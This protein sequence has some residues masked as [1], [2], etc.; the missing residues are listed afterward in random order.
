MSRWQYHFL[1]FFF[2]QRASK[3]SVALA[4][5][6]ERTHAG[7]RQQCA[8]EWT[9]RRYEWLQETISTRSG[10]PKHHS[11]AE[12][13][14]I[15]ATFNNPKV[16]HV[17]R[18]GFLMEFLMICNFKGQK[19]QTYILTCAFPPWSAISTN[20]VFIKKLKLPLTQYLCLWG[21][22]GKMRV[23]RYDTRGRSLHTLG[24]HRAV[25]WRLVW[26]STNACSLFVIGLKVLSC[27]F[28]K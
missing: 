28:N 5:V 23:W 21:Q 25:S 26:Q 12:L 16:S 17:T 9:H 10:L 11:K 18:R 22:F 20:N 14:P 19:C 13:H 15:S 6:S 27:N 2:W 1:F 8:Y 24:Q 7:K 4:N 3:E